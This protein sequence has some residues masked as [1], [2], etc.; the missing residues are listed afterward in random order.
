M[1]T[2]FVLLALLAAA[3]AG[4]QTTDPRE[5]KL[6]AEFRREG[7]HLKEK[8]SGFNPKA[9][10]ACAIVVATGQPVHLA[11]GTIAPQNG[12]GLG[13]A[14]VTGRNTE[15]WRLK[16]NA[17]A[18]ASPTGAWRGGVYMKAVFVKTKTRTVGTGRST[19]GPSP[20]TATA[21]QPVINVYEQSTSLPKLDFYGLGPDSVR[22]DRAA[23]GMTQH[24]VGGSTVWSLRRARGLN[25]AFLGEG[26]GRWTSIRSS[27]DHSAPAIAL[28]FNNASAPGLDNQ[29]AVLQLSEGIRIRPILG[30]DAIRLDYS[31]RYKQFVGAGFQRWI[32]D[33]QH[34]IPLYHHVD[35]IDPRRSADQKGPDDCGST[36]ESFTRNREGAINLRAYASRS[37]VA[38]GGF[39]PFYYQETVGGSNLSGERMLASYDDY[40]FRGPHVL[41]FQESIEHSLG[42]LPI[43]LLLF[44]EQGS[45]FRQEQMFALGSLRGTFGAGLTIRA[46]GFPLVFLSWATGK[47]GRHVAFSVNASLLGGSSRPSFY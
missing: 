16:W 1:K 25:L 15:T 22:G 27:S 4:A 17:D 37:V 21:E 11:F 23:F 18:V 33:L 12:F 39:V 47:E 10:G 19:G 28:R 5:T 8:C 26:N 24:V 3:P 14:F 31:V 29:P 35:T 9:L 20:G 38:S 6:A 2:A 36:C 7:E 43:G 41:M 42:K 34:E 46:G 44:G 32:V 13:G 40:R 30:P 45:V